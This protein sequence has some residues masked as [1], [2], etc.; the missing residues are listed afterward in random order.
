MICDEDDFEFF[1]KKLSRQKQRDLNV[2]VLKRDNEYK[3]FVVMSMCNSSI[4]TNTMGVLHGL[5]SNGEIITVFHP[6]KDSGTFIPILVGK[7]LLN[8]YPLS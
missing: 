2:R 5:F 6:E 3:D 4:V 7:E 8:W 1:S